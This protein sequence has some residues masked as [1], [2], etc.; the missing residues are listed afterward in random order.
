MCHL[1]W[2]S[3]RLLVG[4]DPIEKAFIYAETRQHRNFVEV[5]IQTGCLY[6]SL[7]VVFA[8]E[9]F[10]PNGNFSTL[11][12]FRFLWVSEWK[13]GLKRKQRIK[14]ESYHSSRHTHSKNSKSSTDKQAR[15]HG[16]IFQFFLADCKPKL[17]GRVTM[18]RR[19]RQSRQSYHLGGRSSKDLPPKTGSR[20]SRGGLASSAPPKR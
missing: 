15:G 14:R 8:R 2:H 6:Y 11:D 12:W 3:Y 20:R 9:I 4:D 16:I 18:M 17:A 10:L 19:S 1:R 13:T 5:V 7:T